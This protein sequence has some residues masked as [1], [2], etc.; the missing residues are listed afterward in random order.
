MPST[1]ERILYAST[2]M[3]ALMEY[4]L[5]GNL[6]VACYAGMYVL[7]IL[8]SMFGFTEDRQGLWSIQFVNTVSTV[9]ID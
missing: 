3:Q 8:E 9:C 7:Y 4:P 2:P 6:E 1:T 5:K